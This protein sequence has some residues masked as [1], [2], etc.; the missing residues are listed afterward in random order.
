MK[1]MISPSILSADFAHL[2]K[3]IDMINRSE[4]AWVHIDIMDGV[5][6]PNISFGF[7]VLKYV[8]ELSEKPLDVH[9]MIVQP[10]KF[11]P[12]V[13][14]L[15]AH[16]MNVHYEACPHIHRVLQQIREAGMQPAV[17]INP[18]TPV[19]LLQDIIREVYL[20]LIMSVNPGFGGQKFIEHS[21]EKVREL[22]ELIDRTGSNALIEVD[23]GVNLETGARLIAAGADVLVAGNAIFAAD[24]PEEMIKMLMNAH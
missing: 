21:I 12:E 14:A 2:A 8:A 7:P 5:F 22:R 1:A 15:G 11:I 23:G 13:K 16:V 9:L 18:G 24:E 4:A 3:D 6:V 20:V 10:E 19:A 17:T